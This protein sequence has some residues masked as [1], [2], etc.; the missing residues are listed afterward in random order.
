MNTDRKFFI[1]T[2]TLL[3][4]FAVAIIINAAINFRSYSLQ[5]TREKSQLVAQIVRDGLTAHMLTN[6]MDKRS[7]FLRSIARTN[8]IKNLW[9]VRSAKV[10]KQFGKGM[11]SEKPKDAI[12]REVLRKGEPVKRLFEN[13][14][15]AIFRITIPYKASAYSD[16]NCLACHKVNEGDVLGA[17]SL[18]FDIGSIRREGIITLLKIGAITLIFI[19]L[20]LIAVRILTK[21]Y[22]DFFGTLQNSLKHARKGDFSLKVH[23]KIKAT[24]VQAVCEL[25][26]MLIEKFQNTIGTIEHKLAILLKASSG[27]CRDPLEKA[28]KT[29]DMLSDIHRFKM[30]IEHDSSVA[31]IFERIAKVIRIV[32]KTESFLIYEIDSKRNLRTIVYKTV[33]EIV[34][35]KISMEN[36]HECR[37]FR[38]QSTV[39]S[40]LFPQLCKSYTGSFAFHYCIPFSVTDSYS[41]VIMLLCEEQ[42]EVT[43]F[44]ENLF[45]LR[46]YLENAKPVIESRLLMEK[47]KDRSL[48]DGLTGVYNRKFIEEFI[49]KANLQAERHATSYAVLML[50]IDYF[51]QVNDQ[52]GHDIG[53]KFIKLLTQTIEK[54]I[55]KADIVARYGGEE[56][57]LLLHESSFKGAEAVAEKIRDSF[58]KKAILVNGKHINKTVSIGISFFPENAK[59]LREAIKYADV[60]LY[61][62][63]ESGRNRVVVF[64]AEMYQ[65]EQY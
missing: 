14:E 5:N 31:Q 4:L 23:T 51:K 6:T 25:Y 29:I 35:S 59:A 2:A 46:N 21:P 3:L 64:K 38:T 13:S 56:F 9:I 28:S 60:A 27:N 43:Y 42:K 44:K 18:E 11:T 41:I 1:F 53:D 12:D 39:S 61:K 65:H 22:L 8:E 57:V 54:N 50:D 24:D 17:I 63:K 49:D 10:E 48:R 58:S 47:L 20:A 62:A 32:M 15:D 55:R 33:D 16:P 45:T 30:T 37:A 7:F 34:C 40:D 26:N 52:Y 19:I 36:A